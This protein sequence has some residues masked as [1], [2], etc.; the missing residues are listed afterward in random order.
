MVAAISSSEEDTSSM[1]DDIS[2]IEDETCS[3]PAACSAAPWESV[4]A[5]AESCS[6]PA[7]TVAAT[8]LMSSTFAR[9]RGR[10]SNDD[11][12]ASSAGSIAT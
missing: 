1:E 2:F 9:A 7:L 5:E 10:L 11:R 3:T 4:F 6:L 8:P 12:I